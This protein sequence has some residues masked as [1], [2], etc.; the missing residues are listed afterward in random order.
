MTEFNTQQRSAVEYPPEPLLIL[1]GAGTGKTT[2]IVGRMAYLIQQRKVDPDS[3][4]ALTFTN[5]AASHLKQKLIEEIGE[6]GGEI[7]ACTFHS[8]AHEQTNTYFSKLG[9]FCFF[10]LT[11][12][13]A[14]RPCVVA[15]PIDGIMHGCSHSNVCQFLEGA[16]T[17][18][19]LLPLKQCTDHSF[20]FVLS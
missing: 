11:A 19:A 20:I 17:R 18:A 3:I 1:A 15:S 9:Y 8:F 14:N 13:Q 10:I 7:K 2:T 4:L 5:D 12:F 16:L 6:I